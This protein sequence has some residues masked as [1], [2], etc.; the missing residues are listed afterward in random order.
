M[1]HPLS[2]ENGWVIETIYP[3]CC[4]RAGVVLFREACV[5]DRSRIDFQ[6]WRG[7][8]IMDSRVVV[9][10]SGN[11]D[12]GTDSSVKMGKTWAW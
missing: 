12:Q 7:E 4:C 1:T 11:R 9:Q 10:E 8:T 3:V 6:K 2:I 5:E